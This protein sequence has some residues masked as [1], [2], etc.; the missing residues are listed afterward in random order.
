MHQGTYVSRQEVKGDYTI[1]ETNL[2]Y[3]EIIKSGMIVWC[4]LNISGKW[5]MWSSTAF[6]FEDQG[7]AVMFK[8]NF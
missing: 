7:D 2:T 3:N 8:I 5:T 6:A 4:I 1:V